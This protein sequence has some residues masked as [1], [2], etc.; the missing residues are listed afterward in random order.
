MAAADDDDQH[1]RWR[2]AILE[3]LVDLRR[4]EAPDGNPWKQDL[5]HQAVDNLRPDAPDRDVDVIPLLEQHAEDI[6]SRPQQNPRRA[7]P[8]DQADHNITRRKKRRYEYRKIQEM[9]RSDRKRCSTIILQGHW[10]YDHL[11]AAPKVTKQDQEGYWGRLFSRESPADD[12]PVH[13]VRPHQWTTVEPITTAEISNTLKRMPK[14]TA[15]GPDRITIRQLLSCPLRTLAMTL[16]LWLLTGH[17][18]SAMKHARTT[19]IPK[20]PEA[21]TPDKFRPITVTSVVARLFSKILAR[22]AST[23]CPLDPL[24]RAFLPADGAAENVTLL[25]LKI[26]AAKEALQPLAIAWLDVAK[27]FDSVSHHTITRAAERIGMPPPAVQIVKAMYDG[28][29]TEVRRDTK[30]RVTRGVRQGDPLSPHLFNAVIDEAVSGVDG[31]GADAAPI[32]AF[33]DDL[34]LTARTPAMLQHR[35]TQTTDRLAL[36]GLDINA[37]KCRVSI[38]AVDG[39]NKR[40]YLDTTTTI[41]VNGQPIPNIG[42]TSSIKYLGLEFDADGTRPQTG[43]RLLGHL[44]QLEK[45]P[46]K[47]QQRLFILRTSAIPGALHELVLGRSGRAALR[48]LDQ[49]V[50]QAVRRW[51]HLPKDATDAYIHTSARGGGL[52]IPELAITIP[53]MR[54][55]RLEKLRTS[56]YLPIR[57]TTETPLFRRLLGKCRPVTRNDRLLDTKSKIKDYHRTRL[58]RSVDGGGL[59][60]ADV[61]PACNDWVTSP[62]PPVRGSTFIGIVKV[63]G[64]LHPT[65]QR[66]ARSRGPT[67]TTCDAGCN[68]PETL[69]HISQT[70][71]RTSEVR[72]ARHD[73][74]LALT[75]KFLQDVGATTIREPAIPTPAG[76]RRPDLLVKTNTK[77]AV[78]DAQV[79]ADA[80]DL[81]ASHRRKIDYYNNETIRQYTA[82]TFDRQPQDTDFGSIT[83]NWRGGWSKDSADFLRGLGLKTR[84]LALI[85]IRALEGT[86]RIYQ[87]FRK[88]TRRHAGPARRSA[89]MTGRPP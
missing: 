34:V 80:F 59:R 31:A 45:A 1:Q 72:T 35:V 65:A 22:R 47:P 57:Q 71:P 75:N 23:S 13:P 25:E 85:S 42:S 15:A 26:Q 29:T 43:T 79:V 10:T 40:R 56:D 39:R 64:N 58:L 6:A 70:C 55:T 63:R 81:D 73:R 62:S 30:I 36:A 41:Q 49:Q 69:G 14:N 88:S 20:S 37:A 54:T 67:R 3:T 77:T 17:I 51:L 12:R 38:N 33:A 18:P 4:S 27:A 32:M 53:L 74:V 11:T 68:R 9:Y 19:L 76:V 16:N 61:V 66:A 84:H 83:L 78:V 21:A 82:D 5:L 50:R 89:P 2:T 8:D 7:R 28:A 60:A 52:G 86:N 24:Q 48:R 44:A 46:L 87:S